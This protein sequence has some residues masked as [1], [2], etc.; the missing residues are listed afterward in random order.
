MDAGLY[1]FSFGPHFGEE[2]ELVG[3]GGSG[4]IFLTGCNLKCIFCR[5]CGKQ[6]RRCIYR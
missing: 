6:L 5:L 4:T 2:P 1:I 3:K